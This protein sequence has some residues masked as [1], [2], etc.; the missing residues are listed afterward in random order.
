MMSHYFHHLTMLH[1]QIF[2]FIAGAMSRCMKLQ[3][4]TDKEERGILASIILF[5]FPTWNWI[6]IQYPHTPIFSLF[7]TSLLVHSILGMID[8][9]ITYFYQCIRPG[10]RRKLLAQNNGNQV[11]YILGAELMSSQWKAT[12]S[13]INLSAIIVLSLLRLCMQ[14]DM[15]KILPAL[16][17]LAA[18]MSMFHFCKAYL[19]AY[20]DLPKI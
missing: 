11:N 15:D 19:D 9:P 12:L 16:A 18:A 7:Q 1:R 13:L 10:I 14:D 8:G 17:T 20:V 2:T 6:V 5:L 3:N 4:I